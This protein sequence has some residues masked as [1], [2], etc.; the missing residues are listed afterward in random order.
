M[1]TIQQVIQTL[2]TVEQNPV[3]HPEVD[4]YSHTAFV[5]HQVKDHPLLMWVALF[6]DLGK[7][8]TTEFNA[9]KQSFT[10][11]GHE[12]KS[13]DYVDEFKHTLPSSVNIGDLKLLVKHHMKIKFLGQMRQIKIDAFKKE[14]GSLLP[15][16]EEFNKADDARGFWNRTTRD[17][18]NNIKHEFQ[19][20]VDT[21]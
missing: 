8:E 12:F 14:L 21:L 13:L 11:Y 2:K 15:V 20:W 5:W 19:K 1:R 10:S 3:W 18:R 7:I 9:D 4:V 16:M 6:H 17:E